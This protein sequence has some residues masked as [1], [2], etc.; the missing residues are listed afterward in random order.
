M[1]S[2]W[3]WKQK[4]NLGR[5]QTTVLIG[6]LKILVDS[7]SLLNSYHILLFLYFY[8]QKYIVPLSRSKVTYSE[9]LSVF[10]QEKVILKYGSRIVGEGMQTI[11]NATKM[12]QNLESSLLMLK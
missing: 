5:T 9:K 7:P 4:K 6:N 3:I 12:L 1:K 11:L 8:K 10:I 2:V